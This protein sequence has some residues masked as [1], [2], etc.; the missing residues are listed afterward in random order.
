MAFLRITEI[1]NLAYRIDLAA[2]QSSGL[3]IDDD[4]ALDLPSLSDTLVCVRKALPCFL[5]EL[6][7]IA[8]RIL[9]GSGRSWSKRLS[10]IYPR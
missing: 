4:G 3:S 2:D 10:D 6:D 1:S 9:T 8:V 5:D 7:E